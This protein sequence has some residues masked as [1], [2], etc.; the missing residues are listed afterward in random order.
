[1]I[2]A[3]AN[4]LLRSVIATA[5]WTHFSVFHLLLS[6][7]LRPVN[8]ILSLSLNCLCPLLNNFHIPHTLFS[9]TLSSRRRSSTFQPHFLQ[10]SNPS[11]LCPHNHEAHPR[12]LGHPCTQRCRPGRMARPHQY[13][14]HSR[15]YTY[16]LRRCMH[17]W[18][19][20]DRANGACGGEATGAA[21]AQLLKSC[22]CHDRG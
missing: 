11:P 5:T 17:A 2:R 14:A 22:P 6:L 19:L 8:S 7:P 10:P 21:L 1:M 20:R 9:H 15:G 4:A 12:P 3:S 13:T 18:R 16:R